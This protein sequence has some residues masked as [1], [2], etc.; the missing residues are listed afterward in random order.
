MGG[1]GAFFTGFLCP[2]RGHRLMSVDLFATAPTNH[3]GLPQ[4]P[5]V[6]LSSDAKQDSLA[7]QEQAAQNAA[8]HEM[9]D[10]RMGNV[11]TW[12]AQHVRRAALSVKKHSAIRK[13]ALGFDAA[14]TQLED[15]AKQHFDPAYYRAQYPDVAGSGIDP[16]DHFMSFGY[17]EGRQPNA[18]FSPAKYL[19][20]I[21]HAD[22]KKIN[23]FLHYLSAQHPTTLPKRLAPK[24]RA[25]VGID[26]EQS[27]IGTSEQQRLVVLEAPDRKII[28]LVAPAFDQDYYLAQYPD[29]AEAEVDP[30]LHFLTMGWLQGRDPS[31]AFSTR[32]YLRHNADIRRG[33]M[34]PFVHYLQSGKNEKWRKSA[35]V[36]SADVLER[37]ENNPDLIAKV[38]AATALDPMVALPRQP[39]VVTSPTRNAAEPAKIAKALRNHFAG[40]S[41]KYVIIMPHIRMSGAARIAAIFAKALT[42]I[43][44]K[45]DVLVITSDSSEDDYRKWFSSEIEV[46]DLSQYLLGQNEADQYALLVDVLR[47]VNCRMMFN[48]NSR[49]VWDALNTIGRQLSQDLKIASYLFCW[50]EDKEGRRVGYP[51]QWLRNSID[52]HHMVFTDTEY[53]AQHIRTRFGTD[54]VADGA[55]VQALNAP[56][57]APSVPAADGEGAQ[58]VL[59]AGRFDTQKRI[60]ILVEIARANPHI[61]FDV[62]GKSV[63]NK[64]G[65][66]PFNPPKNMIEMGTFSDPSEV[67]PTPYA[68]F[69]YTAQWD[70]LPS[71]LIEMGQTGIPIIAPRIGGIHE[72]I[73]EDTGWLIEDY[74]DV[75]GY[76][77]ALRS[78][79]S[80]P[81]EAKNRAQNLRAKIEN[82]FTL[83]NYQEQI[84][85]A[86]A[87]HDT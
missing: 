87:P 37:F 45:N 18:W 30:L 4:I 23:A 46:F 24:D 2:K 13:A 50:D 69:V 42:G 28:N 21:P 66:A 6:Y 85:Q 68:A 9:K 44:D 20:N 84:N 38:A 64:D 16:F 58:R 31:A 67:M 3:T 32:Y 70:G 83:E 22:R 60:D 35:D 33:R 39:R 48:I 75:A 51:I 1:A 72:L 12:F 17:L 71:V 5:L 77:A 78:I 10:H 40:R 57:E 82:E 65:L 41:Y 7:P 25:L 29:V 59:W 36:Q 79:Q 81:K 56:V 74:T 14:P 34:N 8:S 53:L 76:T 61:R 62:Y 63:L 26:V 55:H 80:D 43:R 47:G 15:L 11:K 52:F 86:M 73:Y 27:E 19:A 54:L 49:L